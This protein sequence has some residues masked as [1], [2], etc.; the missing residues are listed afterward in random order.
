MTSRIAVAAAVAVAGGSIGG[1]KLP[2]KPLST[3][4]KLQPAHV[5]QSL[6]PEGVPVPKAPALAPAGP[7]FGSTVD[8]I[9]CGATEQV[10]YH[11]HA[12]LSVFDLG[13]PRQIP[14]GIGIVPPRQIQQTPLGPGVVGGQCFFWLHTHVADGIIHIESPTKRIYT[15]G[16][17]FDV[18]REPL[19]AT[20]VGPLR[21]RVTAIYDGEVYAGNPRSIPLEPHAQIQ[22]EV[23]RPLVA[24]VRITKWYGL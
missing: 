22:L 17:F 23:G 7:E 20:R 10:A 15:L 8:G 12:R 3:L 6:G 14:M 4:G 16:D 19:S 24:P 13:K 9:K 18:W 5:R 11:I 21:G 1:T 2:L